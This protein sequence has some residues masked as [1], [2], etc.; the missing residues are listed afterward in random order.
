MGQPV[1]AAFF[2]GAQTQANKCCLCPLFFWRFVSGNITA[3][4]LWCVFTSGLNHAD[5]PNRLSWWRCLCPFTLEQFPSFGVLFFPLR[6]FGLTKRSKR[7]SSFFIWDRTK[8]VRQSRYRRL[9]TSIAS[10]SVIPMRNVVL[11]GTMLQ[12]SSFQCNNRQLRCAWK[13][14]G[15]RWR[16][17]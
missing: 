7:S 1:W 13:K 17:F 10:I 2:V 3:P 16:N 15:S 5:R 6:V 4:L 11:C 8:N 12:V 14:K 9:F